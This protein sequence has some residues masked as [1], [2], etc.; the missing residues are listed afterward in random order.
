MTWNNKDTHQFDCRLGTLAKV[1]IFLPSVPPRQK[2]NETLVILFTNS[3][4]Q[5]YE[6]FTQCNH[7]M[8]ALAMSDLF[9]LFLMC[10]KLRFSRALKVQQATG[11]TNVDLLY[12][13]DSIE[14]AYLE[15]LTL[16][17]PE[18]NQSKQP[19]TLQCTIFMAWKQWSS[20]LQTLLTSDLQ[21]QR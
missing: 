12:F 18:I 2:K 11:W 8:P 20:T 4:T 1:S 6:I 3:V 21:L 7:R 15:R 19:L 5:S 16:W 13:P 14:I 10:S 9:V 17:C